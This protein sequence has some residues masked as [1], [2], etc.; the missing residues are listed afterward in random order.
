MELATRSHLGLGLKLVLLLVVFSTLSS[1]SMADQVLYPTKSLFTGQSL[2]V[3][4]LA[5]VMQSDCNL[6]LYR[7]NS[8]IWSTNTNGQGSGCRVTMQRDG[9]LVVY[10]GN[11]KAVWASGT[12][13]KDGNYALVLQRDGNLVLYGPSFWATGTNEAGVEAVGPSVPKISLPTSR[14][15]ATLAAT[16]AGVGGRKAVAGV[17]S[18]N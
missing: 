9:N 14:G 3:N 5:L 18:N 12:D 17:G 6:V 16:G 4:N 2:N 15:R 13:R 10:N 8:A 7:G 11:G 1:P